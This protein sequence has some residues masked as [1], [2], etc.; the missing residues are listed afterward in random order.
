MSGTSGMRKSRDRNEL[1]TD[2]KDSNCFAVLHTKLSEDDMKKLLADAMIDVS[3]GDKYANMG[4]NI[5]NTPVKH[6]F[7]CCS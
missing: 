1:V 5:L 3:L 2:V 4:L 6:A 7:V